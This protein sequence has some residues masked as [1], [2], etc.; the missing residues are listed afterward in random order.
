[1]RSNIF[2]PINLFKRSVCM[3]T[4]VKMGPPDAILGIAEAF[5]RDTNPKKVNLGAGAYRDDNG[6]PFVL[7]S[8]K[9][10]E[11]RLLKQNLDKEYAGIAGL[12]DF[13]KLA[14]QLAMGAKS[15]VV[16]SGRNA[17]V[18]SI[19]GTG[20]LYIAAA[21]LN[22]FAEHKDIWVPTPTWG[23]HK[24]VFTH[25]GL[26]VHQYRY[27]DPATCG[28]DA[29][30]CLSD[31][32]KI[33]KGHTVLL[34]ACAHNPTGVDPST[35]Q[36]REIG[37]VIK[38]RELFPFFDFAYQ[39]FASGDVDRDA[40]A[41][42]CFADEFQFPTMFFAQSFA[43]NMGLYGE[44]VGALT[45]LCSSTEEMERCLSQLKILIRATYSNPP[46]H[47]ARIATEVLSDPD[48]RLQWLK[49]VKLMADR[50]IS[51]RHSLV[52]FLTKEGSQHNWS[53]ITNQIGMFCFSG[54]TPEQVDRLTKEYSIYL[55]RDGRISIA[56]LS[57][58]NV[59]YLAHA[60]HQVTK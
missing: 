14:F 30:G 6:K 33:P 13:C 27:Y 5:K 25:G 41:L 31:L 24:S 39:G 45:L 4:N 44:R 57:S 7:P 26:R 56:G 58:K 48:L 47:G 50:I 54:L 60:I 11:E 16:S 43:K 23:N 18:Q 40:A 1:M 21:F 12:G 15:P 53:H 34:H 38:S 8:V 20:A 2:L 51:M 29:S 52:D 32:G 49:D 59:Q 9:A 19:S 17:T 10:A 28:F 42:R 37:H 46:I 3:W 22:S 36:W 55:T 35:E